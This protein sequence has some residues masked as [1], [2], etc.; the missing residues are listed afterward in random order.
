MSIDIFGEVCYNGEIGLGDCSWYILIER[1]ML[2]EAKLRSNKTKGDEEND[3]DFW[4]VAVVKFYF[5]LGGEALLWRKTEY[6]L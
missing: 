2:I 1:V 4:N 3:Q 6:G 5:L